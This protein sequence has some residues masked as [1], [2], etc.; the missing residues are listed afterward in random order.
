MNDDNNVKS[1]SDIPTNEQSWKSMA[2]M[3]AA[4]AIGSALVFGLVYMRR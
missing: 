1:S 2:Y 4:T 3:G